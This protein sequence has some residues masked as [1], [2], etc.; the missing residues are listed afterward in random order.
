MLAKEPRFRGDVL[1]AISEQNERFFMD[2]DY[3]A[4]AGKSRVN[5]V[6]ESKVRLS[7]AGRA[8]QLYRL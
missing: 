1:E 8:R 6:F 4:S 5:S 2:Q 3:P 7:L